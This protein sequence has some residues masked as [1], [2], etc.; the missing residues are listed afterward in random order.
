[1][2]NKTTS[3]LVETPVSQRPVVVFQGVVMTVPEGMT[4]Y[5]FMKELRG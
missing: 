3:T 4:T 2:E 1:M 5:E